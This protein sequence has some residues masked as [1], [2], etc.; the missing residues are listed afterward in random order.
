MT[1]DELL[2][3]Q[4]RYQELWT[5]AR[6]ERDAGNIQGAVDL[7]ASAWTYV[8]G[9]MRYEEKY[10]GREFDSIEAIDLVLEEAP[11]LLDFAHLDELEGLLKSKRRIDK[12]AEADLADELSEARNALNLAYRICDCLDRRGPL[13]RKDLIESEDVAEETTR[14]LNKMEAAGLVHR[15]SHGQYVFR[16]PMEQRFSAKC[17]TCGFSLSEILCKLLDERTCEKC[18]SEELPVLLSRVD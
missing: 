6:S 16:S 1:K 2:A 13:A 15:D 12:K 5:R 17:P 10:E 9:M 14:A 3:H 8:D 18:R 4:Q 11:Y 7:A